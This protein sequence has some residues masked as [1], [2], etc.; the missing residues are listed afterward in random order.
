MFVYF[1][2]NTTLESVINLI[3][4]NVTNSANTNTHQ[5]DNLSKEERSALYSLKER[6]DIVIKPADKGSAVVVM[7]KSD[8]IQEAERQLSDNRFYKK[9]DSDPTVDFTQKIT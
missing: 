1:S 6:D 8:Y 7:D 5:H 2:K 3:K 9:L 4:S